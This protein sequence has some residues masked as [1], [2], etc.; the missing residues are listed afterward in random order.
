MRLQDRILLFGVCVLLGTIGTVVPQEEEEPPGDKGD[1]TITQESFDPDPVWI[2]SDTYVTFKLKA[3]PPENHPDANIAHQTYTIT[4]NDSGNGES[5]GGI[6]KSV[7]AGGLYFEIS[8]DGTT[9]TYDEDYPDYVPEEIGVTVAFSGPYENN[10]GLDG[11]VTFEHL[12]ESTDGDDDGDVTVVKC[13]FYPDPLTVDVGDEESLTAYVQPEEEASNIVIRLGG[14]RLVRQ[15]PASL[16]NAQ[17][18]DLIVH[19]DAAGTIEAFALLQGEE[20][21]DS[22]TINVYDPHITIGDVVRGPG[23]PNSV[24]PGGNPATIQ[25]TVSGLGPGEYFQLVADNGSDPLAGSASV[26]PSQM[27]ASGTVQVSGGAQTE[28]NHISLRIVGQLNGNAQD[29]RGRS[30]NSFAV[31]AHPESYSD[32]YFGD[33]NGAALGL[34]VQDGWSSDGGGPIS[35]Q[36][37]KA[38]ISE[39]VDEDQCN[40]PPFTQGA[41]QHSG[42]NPADKL[43]IDSHTVGRTSVSLGPAGQKSKTQVCIFKCERCGAIDADLPRSGFRIIHYVYQSGGNWVHVTTK[44]GAATS[45][46]GH[47]SDAGTGNASSSEHILRTPTPTPSPSPTPTTTP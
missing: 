27:T 39:L 36:L 35:Q 46:G 14:E 38:W 41:S 4:L 29:V 18:P 9:A 23:L 43:T 7:E 5:S 37:T 26:T 33:I 28:P 25:V 47:S 20:G 10:V 16:T 32:Y 17:P 40:S 30:P 2:N 21:A 1:L 15:R 34:A 44:F 12:Y 11:A 19:G 8:S 31:C 3:T 6:I 22:A 13:T 42:Y 24:S 45:A